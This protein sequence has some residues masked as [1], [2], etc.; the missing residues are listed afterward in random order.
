MAPSLPAGQPNC[1][2]RGGSHH[3][4]LPQD[5][6]QCHWDQGAPC[7][8]LPGAPLLQV[9]SECLKDLLALGT[10]HQASSHATPHPPSNILLKPQLSHPL[11]FPP[12]QAQVLPPDTVSPGPNLYLEPSPSPATFNST[13][14]LYC[15]T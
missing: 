7:T 2:R 8:N 6:P 9:D 15:P 11:P 14:H 10:W 5:S 4:P 13:Q 12:L 3:L 1:L